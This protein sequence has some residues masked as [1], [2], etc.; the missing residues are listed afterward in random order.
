MDDNALV[1][2]IV[3]VYGTEA[4]LPACIES[5]CNQTYKN[6]QIILPTFYILRVFNLSNLN[7]C[8]MVSHFGFN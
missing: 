1:S 5:I 3:P 2:I 7:K 6:I 4:Y 8:V